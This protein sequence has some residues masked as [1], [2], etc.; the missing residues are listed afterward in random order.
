MLSLKNLFRAPEAKASRTAQVLAFASGGRARWMPRDY[1]TLAREGYL[2][3]AV[4]HRAVRLIAESAA[5][6]HYLLYEGARELE[7]HPLLQLLARPNPRQDGASLF[8]ALYAHMLLAGNAYLEGV[9]LEDEVRELY[10]LR[11]DRIKVVPGANGWAEAYEYTA[12]GRSVRFEQSAER[13]PP[14][15]HLTFF[16]PLDD[17]YGLAPL[18]AAAV[19]VD[20]AIQIAV[21]DTTRTTPPPTP[22]DGERYIVAS[23]ASGA[24]VGRGHAVATWETNAWRFLAPKAGWCVW[25]VADN[26]MLVFD[27]STWMPVSAA[28]GTPFSPDNLPH[29][30]INTAAV[31]TNLLTVRSDDVLFHAIDMDDDGTGDVRLQLSKEAAEN[32]ASVVFANAFSGRAEFGLTGDDDFHLKVS[33]D[34]TAWRDALKFDRTTGR[35][36]FPSGGAREMLTA[37]RTY[38]VRTDGND[39][40]AGFSNTAGGAFKTIQRAYDVIAA[41]LDLGGFTVTVQVAD[42]TYAPPSGTNAL[43]VSQPWTGGGSVKIQGN[44]ST[45]ASVL[46]STTNADAIAT[47]APLPGPLTIKNLKLQTAAAGNGISHRAAG[48]ILI[49]SLVFGAAANAHCFTGAPGAFIRAIS[50]YTITGGAIQHSVATSTSS[51]FMSG[52][53]VTLTGTPA[54]TTFA[55]A[56][57]CSVA[58]WSGTSFS[59]GATGARYI[60][61]INGVIYTG[62]AGPNFFPGSTAGSTASGGQYL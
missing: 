16:H 5:S 15:L 2:A 50:G 3:N 59:G 44:A 41:T 23:G 36:L 51:M 62:G 30:G 21:Q 42:G 54:F 37:D 4:V 18:E 49:G 25:S 17:H 12:G 26:A 45:P 32:T 11:P 14:I 31:E 19:A 39:S 33:A 56:S 48:T 20:D 61:L 43:L 38:Y 27:G 53:V 40:N 22:V 46:L 6:C 8:E 47:A 10:A 55:Q 60:V 9:A 13:V 1:A 28:G 57:G 7:A 58:D 29:L 34:G 24:W 35:V 52:I